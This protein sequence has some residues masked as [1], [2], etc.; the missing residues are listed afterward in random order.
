MFLM[1]DGTVWTCGSNDL[2]QLGHG[3]KMCPVDIP[4]PIE[5]KETEGFS[6]IAAGPQHSVAVCNN[7]AELRETTREVLALERIGHSRVL[8]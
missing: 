8:P 2:G 7:G 1:E 6:Y 4:A 5:T 3:M